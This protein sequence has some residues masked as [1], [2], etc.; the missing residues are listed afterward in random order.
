MD[1]IV[2]GLMSAEG[3]L[4]GYVL[5]RFLFWNA[6]I[7]DP[8]QLRFPLCIASAIIFALGFYI[9]GGEIISNYNLLYDR[10]EKQVRGL[11]LFDLAIACV[12][13]VVGLAISFFLTLPLS[14]LKG[15][16][17]P[18]TIMVNLLFAYLG[19][20]IAVWKR[21][22]ITD[23]RQKS[24]TSLSDSKIVDTSVIIDGRI[25][26]ILRTGFLEG[27]LIIPE[28]VLVELR[29]I[30]DSSD[31][32]RRNRGRLGLEV[33]NKIRDEFGQHVRIEKYD[34]PK[35]VEVDAELVNL[36]QHNNWA[37]L[38]VDYNLNKIASFHRV[39][40]LNINE[41]NNAIKPLAMPGEE[42]CVQIVKDGKEA[43]QGVGYLSDGTMI[44]VEDGRNYIGQTIT[45][46]LTS[47][48]QKATG[49]MIFAKPQAE[50]CLP[51]TGDRRTAISEQRRDSEERRK[52]V[53]VDA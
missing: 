27:E 21:H 53:V 31:P 5:V 45:V 42:L 19:V 32:I 49:R 41:L 39:S 17:L 24:K 14:G 52:G 33:L 51:G 22:D 16:G 44:V 35:G 11:T 43:G 3:A 13:L 38:T 40:V 1:L 37:I 47:V 28:F 2:K 9:A 18:I 30:A 10:L 15:L 12:G 36:A 8:G 23:T 7:A 50:N 6:Q 25:L 4:T 29:H 34:L 46:V 26:E 20:A 48:I